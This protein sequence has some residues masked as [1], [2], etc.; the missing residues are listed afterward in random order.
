MDKE[1]QIDDMVK[2]IRTAFSL[3]ERR[4]QDSGELAISTT[5]PTDDFV[6]TLVDRLNKAKEKNNAIKDYIISLARI[7]MKI[8]T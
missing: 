3:N 6:G 1:E 7:D 2:V 8:N 4:I 5:K